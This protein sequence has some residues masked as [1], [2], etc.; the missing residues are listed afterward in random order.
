[1][2]IW[3]VGAKFFDVN[4]QADRM[5]LTAAFCNF[6]NAPKNGQKHNSHILIW[7][8]NCIQIQMLIS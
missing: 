4:G 2:N 1:M 5:K 6:V 8:Y 7:Q 3:P